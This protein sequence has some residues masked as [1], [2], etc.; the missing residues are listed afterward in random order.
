LGIDVGTTAV[1]AVVFSETGKLLAFA[2]R[3]HGIIR[4]QPGYAELDS[5]GVWLQVADM[6]REVA[7]QTVA[8]PV[9]ALS[10]SS[11]GEALTPVG[12]DRKILGNCI[13]GFDRRGEEA[14]E[15]LAR[16]DP[17]M[18]FERSGNLASPLYGGQKI[19]WLRDNCP[20]LFAGTYKFLA[21][22]DL[23]TY[24]LG[25]EPW[26]D[27]S[28]A[29]RS[30]L[31]DLRR[32]SWSEETLG[33][34]EVPLDKLP[35]VQR[36]GTVIGTLPRRVADD[37]GLPPGV[38]VVLGAHDQCSSALGAG[39]IE[40]GQAAY[41]MG[42]YICVTPT[43][44]AIPLTRPLVEAKLNVEHHAVP[45]LF[46]SFYYN[47]SGGAML[48][49]FRDTFA[50]A[51][52]REA[53]TRRRDVYEDLLAEMPAGPTDL[54]VL[55]HFAPTGPPYFDDRPF[56]LIAGLTL[57]TTR[58]AFVKGLLEGATYY[59]RQGLDKMAA[60]GITIKELRA[61][62]GG[63]QSNAWLQLTADVL[64]RKVLCP[65]VREAGALGAVMLAGWGSGVY[66]SLEEA[67]RV[68][69]GI[70]REFD[71]D[72]SAESAYADSFDRYGLLYSFCQSV[73]RC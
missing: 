43:Y 66:K 60:A 39:V 20:E 49:W 4:A 45:G 62:G 53:L 35:A 40:P 50:S 30:L 10:V 22:G 46:V 9:V 54:L 24:M 48:Q 6:I 64:G 61:T 3:E 15:R 58:G 42:T 63:S 21:W 29:N 33:Y 12:K 17:V 34:L 59:F 18:F 14:T 44:E 36:A 11:M 1:K 8:D 13:L 26:T 23:V 31:F 70:G 72:P 68:L 37:L 38:Q 28:Q 7:A 71:P 51:E 55:P 73:R 65:E 52:H 2:R 56:G 5:H 41:G 57:E 16:L 27:Y 69:V 67:V 19:V 25:A 32:A 47:L